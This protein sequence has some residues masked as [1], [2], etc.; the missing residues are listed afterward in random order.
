MAYRARKAGESLKARKKLEQVYAFI[1]QLDELL[2][3]A[4][5]FSN[6]GKLTKTNELGIT[7]C[8]IPH[9]R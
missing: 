7:G 5:N 6:E 9:I 3:S 8:D 2:S 1:V 4:M